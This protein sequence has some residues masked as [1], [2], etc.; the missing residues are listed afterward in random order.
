MTPETASKI[1]AFTSSWGTGRGAGGM[2]S[3][4]SAAAQNLLYDPQARIQ[5]GPALPEWSWQQVSFG[6]N[7]PVRETQEVRAI[8]IPRGWE[9]ALSVLRVLLVLLLAA[10]L[11][12]RSSPH[13][14]PP[15]KPFASA[16]LLLG[17]IF[18]MLTVGASKASDFPDAT[19]LETLRERVIEKS[20]AF[21]NAA[22]IPLATL[23]LTENA[24]EVTAVVHT[25]AEVAVPLPGRLPAWSPVSVSVDGKPF[26]SLR[27]DDGFLW[28]VLPE[29]VH[30]VK[31]AGLLPESADWEWAF[32]LRPLRVKIDA[33]GWVVNGVNPEGIPGQQVFLTREKKEALRDP[34]YEQQAL[35]SV[36]QVRRNFELGLVWRVQ[37]TVQRLSPPERP[38]FLRVPLLPGENVLTGNTVVTEGQMEV[39]LGAQTSQFSWVSELP[40]THEIALKTRTSDTWVEY[41]S[42]TLS[43]VWNVAIAG[44]APIFEQNTPQLLPV[45]QPW[46]G[47]S[48]TLS[49]TRPEFIPGPTVTVSRVT[50]TTSLG[51]RQRST[52]LE[53][54]LQCTLGEDFSIR[55]PESAE[56]T[57]LT[58][59]G[60]SIPV[61]RSQGA[62]MVPILPG[63]QTIV[64][65]WKTNA[66]LGFRAS[67]DAVTLASPAANISSIIEVPSG[68]WVLWA[69]GPLLGPAVRFWIVL[70]CALVAAVVLT[71]LPSS[72][73][74]FKEWVL[75]ALGLT[76]VPLPSGLLV[77]GWLFLFVW[78]GKPSYSALP[79]WLFNLLQ[80]ALLATTAL[81]LG[82]FVQVVAAGL[83][84]DPRMFIIGND[85]TPDAL[86]W[87]QAGPSD[88]LPQPASFSI[89]IWWYRLLMLFWALWL[90]T[91]LL[92]WLR[93]SWQQFSTNQCFRRR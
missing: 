6:W 74:K 82:V 64:M 36:V 86:R 39:R 63:K 66:E 80:I 56:I 16:S 48:T 49:I 47:E 61:R 22:N 13:K 26:S 41:W 28:V 92:R 81:A 90:A 70:A 14:M 37:T 20:D 35:R 17:A 91:S 15:V 60:A 1:K 32:L 51:V 25:G 69:T 9:Q 23:H 8:F 54:A 88:V 62:V 65:E 30:T 52:R 45:W 87:F 78:R 27:R 68:R 18:L 3:T 85:S 93:W 84:G 46:P 44:L 21:P 38:I 12:R 42:L 43:P 55:I 19:L 33:P 34:A 83:L 10:A 58:L 57:S 89:S 4:Q 77:A 73:L 76:Q 79:I 72:P 53:I 40:I 75:L 5:T 7:G 29:G 11:L 2:T 59:G 71:R 31:I 50:Q 24:L 67:A